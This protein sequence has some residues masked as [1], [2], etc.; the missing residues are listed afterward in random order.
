M[1][2]KIGRVKKNLSLEKLEGVTGITRRTLGGYE[3]GK[4]NCMTL[5]NLKKL[6]MVLELTDHVVLELLK[7]VE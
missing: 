7:E 2:L 4:L 6:I 3:N 5:R 1:I